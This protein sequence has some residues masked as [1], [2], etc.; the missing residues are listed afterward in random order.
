MK[1]FII[2]LFLQI[3]V[4]EPHPNGPIIATSGLDHDIKIWAPT[5][6]EVTD[7]KGLKEVRI[8]I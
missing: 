4:L 7:L 1:A 3:N 2:I 5:L 6:K 8:L